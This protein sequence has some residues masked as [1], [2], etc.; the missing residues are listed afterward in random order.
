MVIDFEIN[1]ATN[2]TETLIRF[3]SLDLIK[4]RNWDELKPAFIKLNKEQKVKIIAWLFFLVSAS[5][6]FTFI[7]LQILTALLED[8]NEIHDSFM[9]PSVQE[10]TF[11]LSDMKLKKPGADE[12]SP[13]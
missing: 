11:H 5:L 13:R 7:A 12:K 6:T 8:E 2:D 4:V 3:L 10:E 9:I 1:M